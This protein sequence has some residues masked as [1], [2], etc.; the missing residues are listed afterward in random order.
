[1]TEHGQRRAWS[2]DRFSNPP[3]ALAIR[4]MIAMPDFDPGSAEPWSSVDRFAG[5]GFAGG[6]MS[7]FDWYHDPENRTRNFSRLREVLAAARAAGIP[8]HLMD[9]FAYPSATAGGEI[10]RRNAEHRAK[11]LFFCLFDGGYFHRIPGGGDFFADLPQGLL[12]K[13]YLLPLPARDRYEPGAA[14]EAAFEPWSHACYRIKMPKGDWHVAAF[15]E[16]EQYEGTYGDRLNYGLRRLANLLD[17]AAME[18][19]LDCIHRV[20]RSELGDLWGKGMPGFFSEEIETAG[21]TAGAQ[22]FPSVPWHA[23]LET[24]CARHGF[25]VYHALLALFLDDT[26][27]EGVTL[28][29]R[30]WHELADRIDACCLQRIERFC[31]EQGVAWIGH[32][33]AH[34]GPYY[35]IP[36]HGPLTRV[37]RR[38]HVPGADFIRRGP[39]VLTS[40]E[41]GRGPGAKLVASTAWL[42]CRA[43]TIAEA[44][45]PGDTWQDQ[46]AAFT[47]HLILGMT[48]MNTFTW[49][50]WARNP[51]LARNMNAYAARCALFLKN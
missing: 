46:R 50:H 19:Y 48:I 4:P 42:S 11:G 25:D 30:F 44:N 39:D 26:T 36:F 33:I 49:R 1:M 51:E 18:S 28:R 27:P 47:Y 41:G 3:L 20:Y 8:F 10:V 6:V 15:V 29:Y 31:S 23:G 32:M 14:V 7:T 24:D 45:A 43:D 13:V 22:T 35:Q 17:P 38:F 2:A 5:L 37:L 9:D 16:R 34:D 12:R 21:V 40:R